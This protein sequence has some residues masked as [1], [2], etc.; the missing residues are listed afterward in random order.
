M[1][2]PK[3]TGKAGQTKLPKFRSELSYRSVIRTR[4]GPPG[5]QSDA[6]THSATAAPLTSFLAC[7]LL[8]SSPHTRTTLSFSLWS[9]LPLVPLLLI[10]SHHHLWPS[11]HLSILLHHLPL[12]SLTCVS[13]LHTSISAS[14]YIT[15]PSFLW[16]VSH[17]STHPSQHPLTSLT[18]PFSGACLITPHIHL[19]ILLHHLPLLSLVRVSLLHTSISASSYITYPSFLWSVSLY[20]TH[21]SQRPLTSLTPPFS[22]LYLITPHIH[23]S[24]LL[25]HLPLLSLACVSLLHTSISASSYITYPSFLWPV[26]HYSTH[27]SQ[28]PLTSLTPPFSGLCLIT[29]HIHLSVLLHHL[30]LLSLVRVSLL[31]TSISASSYITYPSFLWSVSHYSRHPSQHPLT[32]LTPPFSG[33]C[34]ITP[35]IHLSILLHHLP[36]LSLVRVSLLHTSI[37]ASSYITYPSFL[38]PV[39]HYS[40]HPSQHPLT[41]LTP[42]FSGLCLITPHIHLSILLHHLPLLSLACVSLLHTSISAS[43]YITYPSFLW[44][45]SHYSRH[46]S[47]HPLTSLTPPFSGPCL[48]TPDI[49]LSILLHHLPLLSLARVS[50]LHT[51]IS[52]SSYITYP[53]FLWPVS[54]YS[55]HP[56]QHPLTSLTPPFSD[57]CLITPH[58]H[59]S[60]L[61]HHLPL[62]SLARVSLLH[63]SISASSYITYPSFLWSV[64]LYSTHPSQHPLTSL[65]PPFSGPCLFTPHI[66]LS[67]LLHHLPLLSLTCVSLLHT[68]IS[69]SSYITYPSF[70]WSVSHHSTHPSQHP[71]TSLTP[72]FSG[73][74]LITPHIHL[75]ILLHHLPL[76]SLVRVSL[77]HTSISASS[78][79]TYPSFLWPVSL[80]STH[81]SQRPLT[82]LTPPFSGPCLF[83]PHIPL[84]ILLHHLP[85][86]SLSCVSLLHTSISVSSYITY[87]SFLCPVSHYSTHP[88]QYPLTSLTP[89]F[90]GPSLITPHIHLSILLH[91]LPLLSLVRVSL[92]HTSISASSYITYPSFLWSVSHYSTHPYQLPLTSLT[93]P[94]SGLCLITP[95]IHLSILLHH[96]P[97]LSLARVSL[98]HTSISASS[99]ITYP[100]FL[101]PVSHYSTHPSQHPL[102]SLTPP[103]SGPCLITPDIHLSILLHHL[104]LLSLAR[105]SLLH[106]SISAS[107]YIT[108]PSFLW[109]VSLLRTLSDEC[110]QTKT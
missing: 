30:P 90:S 55:T 48:I 102:T 3:D 100:S 58:I 70:L 6:L 37:S 47:Q 25:H 72:P 84:S 24:I 33:P 49:H 78:Y 35:H 59:L 96:L 4:P 53:S 23:L 67:I 26:S 51:S 17:Y 16:P 94:F 18:P 79:I 83:T 62:L 109:P 93:P 21:P 10:L 43:S 61:L 104:P 73:P 85:L 31:Q 91:H 41:S 71:L 1:S 77:L 110:Q 92:L 20:S 22:G 108:Y 68:S 82:S 11:H 105:V 42:P 40:T 63:T 19:S 14:S 89:P 98:L 44:S 97:L 46:P 95:H 27:P 87:P 54:H 50:L 32:S 29:P 28:H 88:S 64:S 12:L 65:T 38:W 99:Y 81:P 2:P 8:P 52:A 80:Y 39:S 66:H 13:L 76:L 57:P 60:I 56:S 34:L 15:Y 107:S 74:C 7:A 5:R 69:A 86:L 101:W 36:L 9:S 45:V 106:T 75:S 103:F